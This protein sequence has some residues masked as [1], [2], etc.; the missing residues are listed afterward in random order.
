MCSLTTPSSG[1]GVGL[2]WDREHQSCHSMS[3]PHD[4]SSLE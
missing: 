2:D 1:L 3:G 4:C